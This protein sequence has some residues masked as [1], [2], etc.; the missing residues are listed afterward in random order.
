M[1]ASF[2]GQLFFWEVEPGNEASIVLCTMHHISKSYCTYRGTRVVSRILVHVFIVLYVRKEKDCQN[3]AELFHSSKYHWESV[4]SRKTNS[5]TYQ[6]HEI[7][8]K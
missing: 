5:E 7:V 4:I 1:L 8:T 2:P 6:I 3:C